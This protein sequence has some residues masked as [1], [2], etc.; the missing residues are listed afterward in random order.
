MQLH[1]HVRLQR[2]GQGQFVMHYKRMVPMRGAPKAKPFLRAV[3]L[4]FAVSLGTMPGAFA[5]DADG[6][7][8]SGGLSSQLNNMPTSQEAA[9]PLPSRLAF[10]HLTAQQGLSSDL[11]QATVEDHTGFIWVGTSNG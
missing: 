6:A 8:S 4:L 10:T 5:L 2:R 3:L 9:Q 11:A 7:V 1:V